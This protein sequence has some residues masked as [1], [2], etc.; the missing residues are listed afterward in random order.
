MQPRL[1]PFVV[2]VALSLT[3]C[4]P[5]HA[6]PRLAHFEHEAPATGEPAPNFTLYDLAGN[7][8]ELADLVGEKPIVLRFGSH[9]CPVYR[10]R[11]FTM[12]GIVE[13]YKDRVHF[14]T[15]YTREAHPV[16]SKSP[17]AEGEWDT[18]WNKAVGVRVREPATE[19]ERLE[20]ALFSHE[21]LKLP[22]P[23][24]VDDM[25]NSVWEAFGSAS[26]PAFV[27][28]REGNVALRQ[29][30]VVPKQIREVLDELLA[31]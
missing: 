31:P 15:V 22:E 11:R 12:E 21:K 5:H 10:Y 30:W 1:I 4:F 17:H 8:V 18:M 14:L 16:G 9:S 27:I 2:F 3:G 29:V 7:S 20:L 13:D 6:G 28:D 19:E 25:D 24:V 23:M 26:A